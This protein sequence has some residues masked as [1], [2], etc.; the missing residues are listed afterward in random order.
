MPLGGKTRTNAAGDVAEKG[1]DHDPPAKEK[2]VPFGILVLV[3]GVLTLVFGNKETSDAWVD[4][5]PLWWRQARSGL[6]PIPLNSTWP[7]FAGTSLLAEDT[8]DVRDVF[9]ASCSSSA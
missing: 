7:H 1:W 4:A 9:S 6:G 8:G 5:L 3:T 2:V